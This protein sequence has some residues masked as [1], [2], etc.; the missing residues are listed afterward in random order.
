MLVPRAVSA[1]GHYRARCPVQGTDTVKPASEQ[2][3]SAPVRPRRAALL[4]KHLST[5]GAC[6]AGLIA[7]VL[8]L[9]VEGTLPR[10]AQVIVL[11]LLTRAAGKR[12]LYSYFIFLML[13]VVFFHLLIPEGRVLL[14][15]GRLAITEGALLTGLHRGL[16][17]IGLVFISLFSIRRDLKLPGK[18]GK[19]ISA[20]LRYFEQIYRKRKSA[21]LARLVQYLDTILYDLEQLPLSTAD[22][23]AR[24][25]ARDIPVIALVSGVLLLPFLYDVS[26]IG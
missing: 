20:T 17:I 7:L 10:L 21:S 22:G 5:P 13:S 6:I 25:R 24:L 8:F 4:E 11:G 18:P 1:K 12:L 16:T 14:S 9:L 26:I 2:E 15:I 3:E 19:L 23:A